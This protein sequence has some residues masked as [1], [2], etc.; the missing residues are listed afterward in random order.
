MHVIQSHLSLRTLLASGHLSLADTIIGS[1][2]INYIT[3]FGTSYKQ[4]PLISAGGHR[5][6]SQIALQPSVNGQFTLYFRQK[7]VHHILC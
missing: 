3:T 2:Q 1:H 6:K 7:S 5:N 4:T